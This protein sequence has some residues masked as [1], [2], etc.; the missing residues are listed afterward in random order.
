M[1]WA[2]GTRR[3][4][5]PEAG[6]EEQETGKGGWEETEPLSVPAGWQWSAPGGL[7]SIPKAQ[8]TST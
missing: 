2:Q 8:G 5:G 6:R 7:D 3:T 4:G 1:S